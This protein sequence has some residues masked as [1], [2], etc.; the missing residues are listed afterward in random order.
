MYPKREK[1]FDLG[2]WGLKE[3]RRKSSR[4]RR[5][6]QRTGRMTTKSKH[7]ADA[8]RVLVSL[9]MPAAQQN[10]RSAVSLLALLDLKPGHNWHQATNPLIGITPIMRWAKAQYG[11]EYAPNTRET[12]RRQ[13]M[14]QMV[15]AG[16]AL[17]NPDDPQRPVNSPKAVYQISPPALKLLR[18]YGSPSWKVDLKAYLSI[19]QTL[20]TQYAAARE[21]H[22]IPVTIAYGK[23]ITL[24]GLLAL[25]R[26][27]IEEFISALRA[28]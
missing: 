17:Y 2:R 16:I 18:A 28:R 5:N 8:V 22:K 27:I 4:D 26:A 14:H 7:L 9:G 10:E 23:A 21:S 19:S 1:L 15:D 12:F 6:V 20:A 25:I 11:K 24:I 13:T 3:P